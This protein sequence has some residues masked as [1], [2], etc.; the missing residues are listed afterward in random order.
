MIS[1]AVTVEP[2][3]MTKSEVARELRCSI[4]KVEY[5]TEVNRIPAP[6][7][8]GKHVRWRR[9]EITEWIMSGCP[10]SDVEAEHAASSTTDA[11]GKA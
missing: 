10:Q 4:R 3:L 6:I 11:D 1:A 5:L 7:R 8:I 9:V 2:S